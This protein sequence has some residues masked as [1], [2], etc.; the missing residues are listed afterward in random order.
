MSKISIKNIAEAIYD[1]KAEPK[2]VVQFLNNKK[3]LS[4]S[5]EILDEL[6]K[7]IDKKEGIVRMKV[8]SAKQIPEN[9][10]RELE[11][12]MKNKYKAKEIVSE[13]FED[14]SLLGGMKIEIGDDTIDGT[15]RNKLNQLE[16][17]LIRS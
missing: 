3:M 11:E 2:M 13:Y 16:K 17:H 7:M 10:K 4:K 14:K 9:K 1:T 6:Q 12:E 5:E 8:K 15:Y